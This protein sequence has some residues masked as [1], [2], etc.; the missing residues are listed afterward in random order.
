MPDLKLIVEDEVEEAGPDF[1][2]EVFK[3]IS[4]RLSGLEANNSYLTAEQVNSIIDK[5]RREPTVNIDTIPPDVYVPVPEVNITSPEI[6]V[7]APVVNVEAPTVQNTIEQPNISVEAPIVTNEVKVDGPVIN[8]PKIKSITFEV[9]E[10]DFDD[11]IVNF[12]ATPIYED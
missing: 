12:V 2:V 3:Q 8:T 6:N 1:F 9:T 5:V 10:R 4:E 7:Q 11:N